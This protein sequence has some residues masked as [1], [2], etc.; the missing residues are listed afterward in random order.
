[1][2]WCL[3]EIGRKGW[4][5]QLRIFFVILGPEYPSPQKAGMYAC[6]RIIYEPRKVSQRTTKVLRM[7]LAQLR[8][9]LALQVACRSQSRQ[10]D[11]KTAGA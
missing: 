7:W 8:N 3:A 11:F 2:T 9:S 1:M 4:G 6:A 10:L 5:A